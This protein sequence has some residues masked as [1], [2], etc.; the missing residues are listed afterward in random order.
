MTASEALAAVGGCVEYRATGELATVVR[1]SVSGNGVLVCFDRGGCQ[2]VEADALL[3]RETFD[4][5]PQTMRKEGRHGQTHAT[6][7]W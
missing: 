3:R 5:R 6:R 7:W 4:V 1:V 2:W